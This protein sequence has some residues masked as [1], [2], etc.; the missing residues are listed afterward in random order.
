MTLVAIDATAESRLHE[1][2]LTADL[3]IRTLLRADAEAKLTT[4]LEPPTAEGTTRYLKT[5]RF[6]REEL[7]A[8]GWGIDNYKNFCRTIHPSHQFSIV[9]SSGDEFTGVD[10]PGQ[11]PCTKYPKGD[12]TALAVKQ[13]AGQGV[14]DLGEAF[15]EPTVEPGELENIG[16][17]SSAWTRNT[18][19][20]RSHFQPASRRG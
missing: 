6:L 15:A 10:I 17:C 2:G 13:N 18:S 8:L 14:L 3:I 20:P 12:L 1:L 5:V 11:V 7:T 19:T 4:G 9:T 16:F